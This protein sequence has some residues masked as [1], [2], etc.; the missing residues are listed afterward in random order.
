VIDQRGAGLIDE[1]AVD[2]VALEVH[3]QVADAPDEYAVRRVHFKADEVSGFF[4]HHTRQR[5]SR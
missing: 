5:L 4:Q 1:D 3:D 2:P